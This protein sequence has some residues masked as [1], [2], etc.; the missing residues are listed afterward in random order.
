MGQP[1][2]QW[3]IL[4]R[5]PDA[6]T[7]FYA[8]LFDWRVDTDNPMG[9]R[10]VDTDSGRGINGGIWP[11]GPTE[12]HPLVQLFV[13]VDDVAAS[14]AQAEQLGGQ[15]VIPPQMLPDGDQLAIV[16]DTEGLS[17]GLMQRHTS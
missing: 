10:M 9:Y 3:Q 12:G 1:V 14:V 13:E 5:D 6:L 8:K 11:I 17:L 4:A 15:V 16:L 2:M 7:S